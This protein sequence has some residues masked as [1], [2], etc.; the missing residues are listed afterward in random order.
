MMLG[1][2]EVL[3]FW[4]DPWLQGTRL[5]DIAPDLTAAVIVRHCK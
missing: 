5:I 3:Y 4:T 1:N 2:G